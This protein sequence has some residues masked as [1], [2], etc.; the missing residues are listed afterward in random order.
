MSST[1]AGIRDPGHLQAEDVYFCLLRSFPFESD[2][3]RK[4][5]GHGRVCILWSAEHELTG[6]VLVLRLAES[7]E[8]LPET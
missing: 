2:S 4:L 6:Q 7:G 8:S 3:G 5:K 1:P